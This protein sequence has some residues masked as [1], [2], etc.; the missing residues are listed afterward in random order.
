M[1][2]QTVMVTGLVRIT[3]RFLEPLHNWHRIVYAVILTSRSII[4]VPTLFY[5]TAF[6]MI[7][8]M[9]SLLPSSILSTAGQPRQTVHWPNIGCQDGIYSL[10]MAPKGQSERI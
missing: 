6:I 5:V 2:R 4:R 10:L 7:P 1:A 8:P 9:G 3:W